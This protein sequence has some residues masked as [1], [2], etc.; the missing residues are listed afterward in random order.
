MTKNTTTLTHRNLPRLAAQTLCGWTFDTVKP[1]DS[2]RAFCLDLG[3]RG[4][5]TRAAMIASMQQ[6]IGLAIDMLQLAADQQPDS[7]LQMA[8]MALSGLTF[9]KDTKWRAQCRQV[10]TQLSDAHLRAMFAFL[11]PDADAAF[12]SI[13]HETAI[14]VGDRVAFACQ[15]LC[16]ARL[17]EYVTQLIEECHATGNLCGLLLTGARAAGIALLQSYVDRHDDPQTAALVAIKFLGTEQL[18]D[19]RVVAWLENYRDLLDRW[20]LFFERCHMQHEIGQLANAPKPPRSIFL[21][22]SFCGKSLT[23]SVS[24]EEAR[25][26]AAAQTAGGVGGVGGGG[27]GAN[28]NKTSSCPNCRKPLPRCAICLM[29]MGTPTAGHAAQAEGVKGATAA[30]VPASSVA[31]TPVAE[32]ATDAAAI[33]GA[34]TPATG[35]TTTTPEGVAAAVPTTPGSEAIVEAGGIGGSGGAGG[36]NGGG[37]NG[38]GNGG[39]GGAATP[40]GAAPVGCSGGGGADVVDGGGFRK[41]KTFARWF[42]WCQTCRHGGH[43]EHMREWFKRHNECPVSSCACRCYSLDLSVPRFAQT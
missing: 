5:Y 38:N 27:G 8:A 9:E 41:S 30:A 32:M 10:R 3:T 24:A 36:G 17:A 18:R 7:H 39:G 23:E 2:L 12:D 31:S 22:C 20:G 29:H 13:L 19:D 33:A 6:Q 37:G 35:A 14:A 25:Q 34:A 16:D 4:E 11:T 26:R 40:A 1:A 43:A 21:L 28:V 15:F 42:T